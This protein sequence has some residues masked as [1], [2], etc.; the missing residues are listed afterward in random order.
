MALSSAFF[1]SQVC[2]SFKVE[3]QRLGCNTS[4]NNIRSQRFGPLLR[5]KKNEVFGQA[6][7]SG[8]RGISKSNVG[9]KWSAVYASLVPCS[10]IASG[11][12][13]LGTAAVLPFYTLMVVAPQAEFTKK[14]VASSLP[15][16]LLGALYAYLLY[17]SWTPDT[18]RVMF[19][20]K[21]WLPE[22][23]GMAKMFSS[24][25]TLA[26]AWIH[27]LTVDL[28]A[29][30]QVYGDGLQNNIETRHSVSLCLLFC[31]VG[32]LVHAITKALTTPT[33]EKIADEDAISTDFI[34]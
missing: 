19:A 29:A 12:F 17:L 25:M 28:F 14:I 11:A 21:Y 15:Y 23:P 32:I 10:E 33:K 13:T 5:S 2:V 8:C 30:R 4:C 16:V 20:S 9:T 34:K 26:S 31:P 18:I 7:R 6:W 24:E 1:T 3:R 27:L 22:L